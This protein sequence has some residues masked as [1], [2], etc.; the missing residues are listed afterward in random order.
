M[1]EEELAKKREREEET[2]EPDRD[3][4]FEY[5]LVGVNVHSGTANMGHYWSYINTNRGVDEKAAEGGVDSTWIKTE[6]DPWME[7]NDSRVSDWEF[8]D[9]K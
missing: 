1:T 2:R 4:C 7:F 6:A 5:K 3:D 9:L 8:K